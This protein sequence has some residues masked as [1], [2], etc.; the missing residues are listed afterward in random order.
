MATELDLLCTQAGILA[1]YYDIWGTR[2]EASD[3]TREAILAALEFRTDTPAWPPV[4]VTWENEPVS[5]PVP[6]GKPVTWRLILEDQQVI[7]GSAGE[8][9]EMSAVGLPGYHRLEM[10]RRGKTLASIPLIVCPRSSYQGGAGRRDWGLAVQLYSLRSAANWGLGDY[11]D[12]AGVVDWAAAAGAGMVGLN[13]LHALFPHNPLHSSPYSPSSRQFLNV[14]HIGIAGLPEYAECSAAQRQVA[15]PA[16]QARLAAL[17]E[18][19]LVDYAGVAALKFGVLETLYRHFRASHLDHNTARA[20]DFRAFQKRGGTELRQFAVYHALQEHF[21]AQ[22]ASVWGW[23]AWPEAYR[24]HDGAAVHAFADAHPERVEWQE[25]LQ[26]LAD[27]QLAAAARRCDELGLAVGLYQD[28]AVGVDKGGAETWV[29]QDLY[30]LDARVGC[31]PDDFNPLGQDWGLPPWIPQRLRGAG[32]A[33]YIAML[34]ANMRYAGALRVDHVMGLMRLYWIPPGMKGD[35]GAYVSYPFEE[36]LGILNLESQRNRCLIVGEDLGT[37]PDEVR[38]ALRDAGVLS[39]KLFYFERQQDGHFFPA[40]WFPEQSLVAASTHDLPTLAGFWLGR[41]IDTRS[42]L[43]LYPRPGMREE[44]LAG[45]ATDRARLLADLAREGLLPEGVSEDPEQSPTM[46]PALTGAIYT[47]L[48]RSPA[49]LALVQAEDM[50]GQTEQAN[51]PGTVDEH[52]NWRR[53][54]CLAVEAWSDDARCRALAE[55]MTAERPGIG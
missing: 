43:D 47:H 32:Y 14:L 11:T 36:L 49:R 3:A 25:W 13:P 1:N 28:L 46:T 30:A 45:R 35:A 26:W 37:V 29:H 19:D 21:H 39:Y 54:L 16:F 15:D 38:H 55:T 6:D 18:A 44:Q 50:I 22:D 10:V 41:D 9:V 8:R 34:R 40:D 33:P 31:P 4:L 52:P 2:H 24:R 20:Q 17:R 48:A 7:E 5:F 12:I 42:A 51:Q 23:P 53:K 27:Q